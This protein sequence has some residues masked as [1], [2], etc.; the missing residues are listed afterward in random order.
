MTVFCCSKAGG[1]A[2][3]ARGGVPGEPLPCGCNAVSLSRRAE[4][5][6][7]WKS[8]PREPD[9]TATER[10]SLT[11]L[12]LHQALTIPIPAIS[13]YKGSGVTATRRSTDFVDFRRFRARSDAASCHYRF[14]TA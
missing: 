11:D 6:N 1:A 9:A 4:A 8:G 14:A 5:A 7:R 3:G 13:D 2:R 12:A 10:G